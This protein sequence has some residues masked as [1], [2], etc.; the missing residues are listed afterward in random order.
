VATASVATASSVADGNSVLAAAQADKKKKP[1]TIRNPEK[2]L[3]LIRL[4]SL[5]FISQFILAQSLI[6]VSDKD[7]MQVLDLLMDWH[8]SSY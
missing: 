3:F 6:Q 5:Y 8:N 1:S 2:P 7:N 4:S